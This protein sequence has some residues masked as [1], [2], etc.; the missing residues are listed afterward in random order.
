M[1]EGRKTAEKQAADAEAL[2]AQQSKKPRRAS[3]ADLL[4][5][6]NSG[7]AATALTGASGA[8]TAPS[9]LSKPTLLGA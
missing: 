4:Y 5:P 2:L 7:T 9:T 3:A 8:A 1:N 6:A